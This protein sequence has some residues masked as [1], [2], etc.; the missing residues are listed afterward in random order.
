MKGSSNPKP[1]PNPSFKSDPPIRSTAEC[2]RIECIS[3]KYRK[4][5]TKVITRANQKEGKCP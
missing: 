2:S 5:K 4:T 3:I 1:K